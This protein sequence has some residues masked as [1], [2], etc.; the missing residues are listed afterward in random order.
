MDPV[1]KNRSHEAGVTCLH[2]NK[3][4]EFVIATGS[5]DNYLRIWDLRYM[6]NPKATIEMPGTMWRVKWHPY[7]C[8][9]LLTACMLDGVHIVKNCDF[10]KLE[11]V[12]SY[13]GHGSIAYGIDWCFLDR[14]KIKAVDFN[15]K[16]LFA[17][18]SFYDCMLCITGV[19]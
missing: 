14:D 2:S 3:E 7:E 11:I 6:K 9:R 16:D 19:S 13:K 1:A 8:D 18:C 5:Y 12:N 4:K 15:S 17:S 10:S